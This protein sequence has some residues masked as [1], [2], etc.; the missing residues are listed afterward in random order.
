ML[1]FRIKK[2]R[3]C[4][5]SDRSLKENV[6]IMLLN[7]QLTRFLREMNLYELIVFFFY[8]IPSGDAGCVCCGTTVPDACC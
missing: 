7:H 4:T 3:K 1:L 5:I 8:P 2:K 6:C